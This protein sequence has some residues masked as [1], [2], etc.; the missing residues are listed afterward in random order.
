MP[1]IAVLM[2]CHDRRAKTVACLRALASSFAR[3]AEL[4]YRVFLVDDGSSD[5]TAAAVAA[6]GVPAT[7][8][9]GPGDLYWNRGMVR[10][11]RAALEHPEPFAGFLLLNDD[12]VVDPDAVERLLAVDAAH[13]HRAVVVGAVRDPDEGQLT[14]GG[15]KRTSRW[16]P[17]RVARLPESD[18]P[19]TAD[20]FNANCVYVPTAVYEAVGTLDP[21]FHH[22]MGDFDYGYRATRLGHPVVVAPGTVGTCERNRKEGTWRDPAVPVRRRLALLASPKGLPRHEWREFLRRHGAPWPGLLAWLPALQVVLSGTA[23]RIAPGRR[24]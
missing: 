22:G 15:V 4:G 17:G 18:T 3:D 11:W 9:E 1:T 23:R 5:G 12:T 2:T 16:H 6:L 14:Y 13:D 8:V 7:L 20:A 21:V 24:P 10:A 19:Q